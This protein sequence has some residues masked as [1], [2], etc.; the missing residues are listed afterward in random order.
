MLRWSLVHDPY[1]EVGA[2][3]FPFGHGVTR[4]YWTTLGVY[5]NV[6]AKFRAPVRLSEAV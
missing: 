4:D 5:H 2:V 1:F 3:D 6:S